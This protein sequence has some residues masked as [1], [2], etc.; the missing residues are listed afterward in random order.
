M[1]RLLAALSAV[2]VAGTTYGDD[3]DSLGNRITGARKSSGSIQQ[4]ILNHTPTPEEKKRAEEWKDK[5]AEKKEALAIVPSNSDYRVW[6][7]GKDPSGDTAKSKPVSSGGHQG[8]F[9]SWGASRIGQ[10]TTTTTTTHK[11]HKSTPKPDTQPILAKLIKI[12]P[13]TVVLQ[14]KDE[15]EIEI[16]RKDLIRADREAI[17]RIAERSAK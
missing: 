11:P 13:D 5:E 7:K 8:T 10:G 9:S 6:H 15:T 2:A 4:A 3:Y 1:K 14:K 17:N 16:A 12:Y